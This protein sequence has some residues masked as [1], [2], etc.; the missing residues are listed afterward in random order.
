MGFA[1]KK[2]VTAF[3]LPPGSFILFLFVCAAFQL[4]RRRSVPATAFL[5]PALLL[6]ALSCPMVST[7]LMASLERGLTIPANPQG[8]VIV[9]LGGG[10]YDRVPDLTGSGAPPEEML[11]RMVTAVRLQR[12]LG[13]PI[14]VTGRCG[15][16]RP[17]A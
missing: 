3:L 11:A 12:R 15:F 16:C 5:L 9:L 2:L 4:R 14:L 13:L 7:S 10:L 17:F 8:D 6:W 1:I